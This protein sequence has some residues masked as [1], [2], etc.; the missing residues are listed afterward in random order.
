[1]SGRTPQQPLIENIGTVPSNLK[2]RQRITR[3]KVDQYQM[4]QL[5]ATYS[6]QALR[7]HPW[8][9]GA[10]LLAVMLGVALAFSVHLINASALGE[11]AQAARSVDGQPDLRLRP[12]QGMLDEALYLQ[13]AAHPDVVLASPRLEFNT[14]A[15]DGQGTP[16][17][18]RTLGLDL[19]QTPLSHPEL[20]P[21]P[22]DPSDR[23]A[24]LSP[25]TVFLNPAAR[26]RWDGQ[27][28]R[29]QTGTALQP[30]RVAGLVGAP[31]PALAVMDIGAAQDF[32]GRLGQL[33]GID[34]RLRP[35]L[36]PQTWA[37]T[38]Q[39]RSD[40][41]AGL[42]LLPPEQAS[43]R[44]DQMSRAYRVNLTVLALVA[45]FTGGFLVFS[46]ISLG[47]AQRA[48]Q[49][50]LLGVLGLTGPQR[51]GL[52]LAE[53]GL[54]GLL[55]SGVG[56]ALGT[57]LAQLALHLLGGDLGGGYFAG[58][59]PRLQWDLGAAAAYGL[60][61][62]T[63]ALAGAWWPARQMQRLP[64]AATLKGLGTLR[65]TSSLR[66]L[67]WCLL[68]AAAA[69]CLAPAVGGLPLAAYL[70]I[71]LL[72]LGGITALPALI[73][74]ALA[75]WA[76][77]RPSVL[78]LLALTRARRQRNSVT[79]A[80]GGVVAALSLAVALTVM[81]ASFRHA[82]MQWLDQVLPA[83]LYVRSAASVDA[84]D[85]QYFSP[86]LEQAAARLPGVQRAQAQRQVALLLNP[87]LP[88]VVLMARVLEHPDTE[89][90][91]VAPSLPVPPGQIG[92]YVS[93]AV[94]ALHGARLGQPLS[95]LDLAL[96]SALHAASPPVFFVAGVWRDYARQS[97]AI[98][99]ARS[100]YQQ[101]TG[102]ERSN[103]LALWLSPEADSD[104][105]QTALRQQA[106][107]ESPG[108]GALLAF[109]TARQIRATS[110]RIFD[111]SFAVTYWL[112]AVAIGI[113]L[114]GIA[115]SFSAQVLARRKEFGLLA[116]LGLTRRQILS[117]VALEGL[118]WTG[119]G[120]LAGVLLGLA[121]AGVL[122]YVVN[123]QSFH[124]SMELWVPW[125]RLG[126]LAAA[127][128]LAGTATAWLSARAAASRDAVLA[129]K[130][131]W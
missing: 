129:V 131:D 48:P 106:E 112:Q 31:G 18:L 58:L 111:R 74:L 22:D 127:V 63:C 79:V 11:F 29:L 1:M 125:A 14:Q 19:L 128:G 120:A 102:D 99:M 83:D 80:V 53:A 82:V 75:S 61:G 28:L 5:F 88:S 122:V 73:D 10:A 55:G 124:W 105:V 67:P 52:I 34:L 68:A 8:R 37:R 91:L 47:A 12:Q 98:V 126:S 4:L 26:Q 93:E 17:A 3:H 6:W 13:L 108:S 66:S 86:A 123:P 32:F 24:L 45:L 57:G 116:H 39:D 41:P 113:G 49:F 7:H 56:L 59:A 65:S 95:T 51:L 64:L 87:S 40:W 25:A 121:V 21:H 114:F 119:L 72:L 117:L 84:A 20:Q 30:V 2:T 62:L 33:S 89:L 103:D 60:L 109:G 107:R 92:I 100:T 118:A 54:L 69:L 44:I 70:A 46:V 115:A 96:G 104:A 16:W 90:P 38:L 81:V 23:L 9:H 71:A 15:L 36:D 97:G 35:G 94:L 27:P 101:L 50:A 43:Q 78:A 77:A 110:L 42:R 76:P 130:E 85:T